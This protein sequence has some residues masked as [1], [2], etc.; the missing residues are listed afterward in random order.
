M[1]VAR[2]SHRRSGPTF[3][4]SGSNVSPAWISVPLDGSAGPLLQ[5]TRNLITF[6][7]HVFVI[8]NHIT[9]KHIKI[10]KNCTGW[11]MTTRSLTG[12]IAVEPY[13]PR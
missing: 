1:N 3:A 4:R 2:I 13:P 10:T 7:D 5:R 12:T 8:V 11:V 6:S 9:A